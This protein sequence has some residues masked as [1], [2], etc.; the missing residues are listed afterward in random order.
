MFGRR[1]ARALTWGVLAG[2]G[3]VAGLAAGSSMA[4]TPL[5]GEMLTQLGLGA[6][7]IAA[8]LGLA[9]PMKDRAR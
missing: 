7:G 4:S 5:D 3:I 6:G 9:L 8:L 1:I 2:G